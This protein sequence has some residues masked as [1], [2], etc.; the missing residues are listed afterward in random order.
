MPNGVQR[1]KLIF[2]N[3]ELKIEHPNEHINFVALKAETSQN[4]ANKNWS[5]S[6]L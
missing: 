2:R 6:I 3:V 5:Q 1:E 4:S